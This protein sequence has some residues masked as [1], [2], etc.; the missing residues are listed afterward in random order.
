[1]IELKAALLFKKKYEQLSIDAALNTAVD[2]QWYNL[3]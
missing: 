3:K 1:M 2:S